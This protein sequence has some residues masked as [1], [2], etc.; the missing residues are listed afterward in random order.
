MLSVM[1]GRGVFA[2]TA[3]WYCVYRSLPVLNDT[4]AT[5]IVG[6][7]GF[8]LA[9]DRL[10]EKTAVRPGFP[11]LNMTIPDAP[12]ASAFCTFTPK[13]QV[14]RWIRAR[15]PGTKPLK[16]ALVQPLAELGLG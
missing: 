11:S 5:G 16:S 9:S 13:L 2:C 14:P 7:I 1:C 4:N 15:L 6:M 12:A 3:F 10:P 8:P